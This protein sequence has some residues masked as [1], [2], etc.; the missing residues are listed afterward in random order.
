MNVFTIKDLENLSGVKAHT[1][2]IWE[3]RYNFL[4]PCRTDTNIRYYC[5]QELKTVLNISLLNK[6]GVKISHIDKM[7]REELNDRLVSL[8]CKEAQQQ[9]I[10]NELIGYM[11][12]LDIGSF[13]RLLDSHIQRS[14]IDKAINQVIF[15]FLNRIGILWLTSHIHPAQERLVTNIIRQKL[16]V[17]IEGVMTHRQVDKTVLLFLPEGEQ[18]ELGLLWV[19]YL[20]KSHGAKVI[21]LGADMPLQDIEFVCKFKRPDYL[22][23]HLTCMA[24]G[25]NFEKF[26]SGITQHIQGIPLFISGQPAQTPIRKMP[27]SVHLR[28]SLEEVLDFVGSL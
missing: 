5:N 26:L 28:R 20:L 4:K 7:S 3:Q 24:G 19:Y 15:P 13:E 10:V 14:G 18:H 27:P 2:R 16:I 25:L 22:Y 21:Y 12:D 17:G 9:R 11:V 1:I 8:S 23:T 6:H